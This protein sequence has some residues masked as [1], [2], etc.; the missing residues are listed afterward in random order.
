M[1]ALKDIVGSKRAEASAR[2]AEADFEAKFQDLKHAAAAASPPRD[3]KGAVTG[4]GGGDGGGEGSGVR[5]IAEIKKGSP[6]KGVIRAD[7]NPVLVA[8]AYEGAG[9]AAISVLTEESYFLGS[10]DDLRAVREAVAIPVLRKDF[11]VDPVQVYD[12]RIA[13]ADCILL[14]VAI[15]DD[16]LLKELLDL[17][18]SLAMAV[19]VEVHTAGELDRAVKV[20]AD[21]IGINNR[22]LAT[23]KTDIATTKRLAGKIP[24]GTLIVS[25]SG[26][27]TSSEIEELSKAGAGA[28]LIGEALMREGDVASKLK[29]LLLEPS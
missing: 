7:F 11:L 18:R 19:L 14:I 6:S 24:K 29:E 13:G 17:G 22:D 5:V 20:G 12:S 3:F 1:D 23:F 15:L 16:A 26:I 25:E 10:M 8:K 21:I 4:E 28:F 9:A 27:N 2:R